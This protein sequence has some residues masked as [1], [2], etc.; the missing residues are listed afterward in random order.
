MSTDTKN[1]QQ[2]LNARSGSRFSNENMGFLGGFAAVFGY[3]IRR[4]R[5][6]I[7]DF[8]EKSKSQLRG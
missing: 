1:S 2:L 7:Q 4:P 6:I 5:K 3:R 8:D